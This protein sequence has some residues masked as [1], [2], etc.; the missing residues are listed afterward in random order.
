MSA[1]DLEISAGVV[2]DEPDVFYF[3]GVFT[4][5]QPVMT[6]ATVRISTVRQRG[7][8]IITTFLDL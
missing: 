3:H 7:F 5:L 2:F 4:M 8:S 1:N 6:R